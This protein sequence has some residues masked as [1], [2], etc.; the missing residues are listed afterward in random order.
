MTINLTAT[1]WMTTFGGL[2][3]GIP[4]IVI[5]SGLVLTPRQ[6]QILAIIGGVGTLLIGL[7]AKD[8]NTH[9]TM[10]QVQASTVKA[11]MKKP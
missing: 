5:N 2:L 4:I 1:N 6:T 8:S 11:E 7:A 3:A 9:S 10:Q